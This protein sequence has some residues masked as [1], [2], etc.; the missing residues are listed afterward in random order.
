MA[1]ATDPYTK[2]RCPLGNLL[3]G[4]RT[5]SMDKPTN[6]M[7][8]DEVLWKDSFHLQ[9]WRDLGYAADV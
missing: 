9:C 7:P 1:P 3:A 5:P 6:L 8:V 4:R 2:T